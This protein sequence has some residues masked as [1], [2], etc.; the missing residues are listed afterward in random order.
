MLEQREFARFWPVAKQAAIRLQLDVLAFG[1]RCWRTFFRLVSVT[2]YNV[3][4]PCKLAISPNALN[5]RNFGSGW[6][7]RINKKR[8]TVIAPAN[9]LTLTLSRQ[10]FS[11]VLGR[12]FNHV[13]RH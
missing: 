13:I 8:I 2:S 9:N 11:M 3:V 6:Q 5:K 10:Q 1:Q 7:R 12:D 4:S